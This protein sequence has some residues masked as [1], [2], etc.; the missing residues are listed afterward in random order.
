MEK[1]C[2]KH[3]KKYEQ[4]SNG[5]KYVC[6]KCCGERVSERRRQ[7]K[8]LAV[9]YKGGKCKMCGYDKCISAL[10]F[11]HLEPTQKDF[12]ISKTGATLSF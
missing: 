10:E 11:H 9:E 3:N 5:G 8:V 6:K 2:E 4:Y 7:L 12:S 1:I